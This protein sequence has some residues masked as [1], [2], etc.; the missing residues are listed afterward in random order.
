[1]IL[2]TTDFLGEPYAAFAYHARGILP[3][4]EASVRCLNADTTFVY[5]RP[6]EESA[7]LNFDPCLFFALSQKDYSKEFPPLANPGEL[8]DRSLEYFKNFIGR[9]SMVI[10]YEL[11]DITL[12]L[13][14]KFEVKYVNIW[15]HPVRFL[16]DELFVVASNIPGVAEKLSPY[17]IS[18]S[19]FFVNARY[20]KAMI[21]RK[22]RVNLD[23]GACVFFGQT[24]NDK[25]LRNEQG[26]Y[27]TV[28]DYAEDL[29]RIAGA[30]PNFY[31][32]RHPLRKTD[33]EL[34]ALKSF[35]GN[36][37]EIAANGYALLSSDN[38]DMVVTIS[39][40]IGIEAY[41]FGKSALFLNKP[42][43]DVRA[44]GAVTLDARLFG[45]DVFSALLGVENPC[46]GEFMF[47]PRNKLRNLL[48][49]YYSY[50]ILKDHYDGK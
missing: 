24:F 1:M 26:G 17:R 39:S 37:R 20:A 47:Q 8:S 7:D 15:L 34:R 35:C 6:G 3:V 40:S 25:T 44:P 42:A 43:V 29:A 33:D 23:P 14:R 36:V 10:G 49:N 5:G 41:Y 27:I 48:D 30:F 21:N 31:Y 22:H 50:P 11:T 32:C 13:L 45:P 9:F 16:D 19:T 2:I 46:P 4:I 12:A 38:L 18:E 28:D